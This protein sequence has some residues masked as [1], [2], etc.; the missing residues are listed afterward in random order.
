MFIWLTI[1][2]P[3]EYWAQNIKS[4]KC[5]NLKLNKIGIEISKTSKYTALHEREHLPNSFG[6]RLKL[7][8]KTFEVLFIRIFYAVIDFIFIRKLYLCI[9]LYI[10]TV[11]VI[12]VRMFCK[13][14][15]LY[16]LESHI[17]ISDII[18]LLVRLIAI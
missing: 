5:W 17:F 15:S 7:Y 11:Q 12:F 13:L 9:V 14:S 10:K 2:R 6:P 4:V 3:S 16:V 8:L 18:R 1:F